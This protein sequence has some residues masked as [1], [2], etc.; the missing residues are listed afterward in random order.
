MSFS[1]YVVIV[2]FI[3]FSLNCYAKA[4]NV[5]GNFEAQYSF[6]FSG[7]TVAKGTLDAKMLDNDTYSV[8]LYGST[9]SFISM[10][11]SLKEKISGT[12][13]IGNGKR[14]IFY[15]SIEK[16]PKKTK[17]IYVRI[18]NNKTAK[19]TVTKDKNKK[20]YVVKSDSRIFSPISLYVFFMANRV[21]IGKTYIRDVVVT[22]HLYKVAITVLKKTI[23]NLD[24]LGRKKGQQ[25]ALEV[26][27]QFYKVEKNG[28]V[29]KYK[30]VKKVVAWIS[31]KPPFIPI[32]IKSWSFMGFFSARLINFKPM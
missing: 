26:L 12:V 21:K 8:S 13:N 11:Y 16:R 24:K 25:E 9:T 20:V 17:I 29:A 19:V 18:L 1:R 10:F 14:D 30:K 22:K 6:E 31:T 3:L 7:M 32:F 27:L 2:L 5:Y 28:K 4:D 23:F 15:E